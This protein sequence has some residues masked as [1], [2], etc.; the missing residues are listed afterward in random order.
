MLNTYITDNSKLCQA[1]QNSEPDT[2]IFGSFCNWSTCFTHK[3]MG[4]KSYLNPVV[5]QSKEWGEGKRSHKNGDKT[6]LQN[7]KTENGQ[8]TL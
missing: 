2:D 7:Y 8:K 6:E 5:E 1:I 4:V 3:F